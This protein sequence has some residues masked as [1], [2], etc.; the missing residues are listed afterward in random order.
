[1]SEQVSSLMEHP[2]FTHTPPVK[3]VPGFATRS[4]DWI[5]RRGHLF[6]LSRNYMKN[7][8]AKMK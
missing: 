2:L 1:M 6:R 4:F 8:K 5:N 3:G 7:L